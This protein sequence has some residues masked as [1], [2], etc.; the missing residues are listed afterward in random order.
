MKPARCSVCGM[1]ARDEPGPQRGEWLTFADYEPADAA[2]LSHPQ[3]LEYFCASHLS[4]A[5]ELKHLTAENA[6][7]QMR[8]K[9]QTK[10]DATPSHTNAYPASGLKRL[11]NWLRS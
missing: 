10:K 11:I 5:L 3:G 8:A 2:A 6:I 4:E 7:T 9:I 1:L